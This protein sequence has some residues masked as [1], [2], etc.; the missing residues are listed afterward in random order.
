MTT[1][2]VDQ[3]LDRLD[4]VRRAGPGR[5]MAKCPAHDDRHPSLG[6]REGQDG[7]SLLHCFAGCPIEDILSALG[8]GIADLFPD[9]QRRPSHHGVVPPKPFRVDWKGHSHQI[10]WFAEELFLRGEKVLA[11]AR[12]LVPSALTEE[13]F[14]LALEAVHSGSCDLEESERLEDLAVNLRDFG[15]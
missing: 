11:L 3:L 10:L 14:D 2:P 9:S 12:N 8:L 15:I 4:G 1:T 5:W 6:I 13:E 7:R